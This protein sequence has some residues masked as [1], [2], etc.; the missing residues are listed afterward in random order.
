MR[1]FGVRR[2]LPLH[3]LIVVSII[4]V[5]AGLYI[6]KPA[7]DKLSTERQELQN[8]ASNSEGAKKKPSLTSLQRDLHTE[9]W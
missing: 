6:W 5:I 2:K 3:Q 4:G 1:K 8:T 9:W 7:F